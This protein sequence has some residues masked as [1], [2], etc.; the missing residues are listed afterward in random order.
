MENYEENVL[1]RMIKIH[2]T[3]VELHF[4]TGNNIMEARI[5]LNASSEH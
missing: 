5:S 2:E 4:H 3:F 1:T